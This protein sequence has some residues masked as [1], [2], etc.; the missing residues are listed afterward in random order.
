VSQDGRCGFAGGLQD[1]RE[2]AV[3]QCSNVAKSNCMLYA[4]DDAVIWKENL[5]GQGAG[6]VTPAAAAATR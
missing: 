5:A 3:K 4:V 1:A 6:G 2:I